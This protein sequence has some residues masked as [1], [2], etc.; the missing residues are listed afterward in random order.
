MLTKDDLIKITNLFID[1]EKR[2][3]TVI[4]SNTKQILIDIG[5]FVEEDLLPQI[6]EKADK[7][8]IERLEKRLVG[9]VISHDQRISDI[10]S[11]PTIAHQLRRKK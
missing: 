5:D 7:A 4:E 11:I 3:K 6:K 9:K 1:S 10:E 8:D 2:M